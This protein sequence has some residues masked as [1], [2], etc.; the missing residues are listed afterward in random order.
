MARDD[1]E[2]LVAGYTLDLARGCLLSDDEPVHLRPQAYEVLRYLA[3]HRG[4]LILKDE[5][6]QQIWQGRAVGNDSLVQCLRDVRQALGPEAGA[7]IRTV[8]GRG[9]LFDPPPPPAALDA[10][11]PAKASAATTIVPIPPSA[12]GARR[13]FIAASLVAFAVLVVAAAAAAYRIAGDPAAEPVAFEQL[14]PSDYS[15][16]TDADL[17]YLRGR[18]LQQQSTGSGIRGAIDL[19]TRAIAV[20][21]GHARAHAA[22][23]EAYRSLAVI[24]YEPSH[25]AFPHAKRAALRA[26]ELDEQLVDAHVSL[27]WVLFFHDWEWAEAEASLKRAIELDPGHAGAHRAYGHL[28]SLLGR[29]DEAILEIGR[30]RELDHRALLTRALEAQFLFYDGRYDEADARLRE[31]LG[32]EPDYWMAHLGLGRIL[33]LRGRVAEAVEPLRRATS[34]SKG[35][36]EP[37]T[38]LAYALARS[39]REAEARELMRELQARSSRSHVPAYAFAMIENGLGN[40]EAALSHLERSVDAREVQATFLGIDARWNWIRPDPRFAALRDRL[41]LR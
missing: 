11:P 14:L 21:P 4:R 5:L 20:A 15:P 26:L 39:S 9:Y 17:L 16:D 31:T 29:H 38:Q 27:G 35:A 37:T 10:S 24:G 8:R 3:A 30:A 25:E 19:Y 7:F 22:L 32:M 18:H 28:L 33:I 2:H 13:R 6:I 36:I 1:R 23:A 40:R 12:T 34:L 41:G